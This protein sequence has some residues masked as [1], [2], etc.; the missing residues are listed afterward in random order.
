MY[1]SPLDIFKKDAHGNPVWIDAVQDLDDARNR[2]SQLAV[3]A[4]PGE[5]F[6]FDQRTRSIVASLNR[7][8]CDR[9]R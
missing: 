4:H 9:H 2:L 6:V 7:S 1:S 8:D 3:A 5:Y